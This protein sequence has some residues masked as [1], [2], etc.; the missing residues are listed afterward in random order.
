M[1]SLGTGCAVLI[2]FEGVSLMEGQDLV[3]HTHLQIQP[4][5]PS[6][7]GKTTHFLKNTIYPCMPC[8]DGA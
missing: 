6:I 3:G 7:L 8:M 5:H 1:G 2:E 4:Q